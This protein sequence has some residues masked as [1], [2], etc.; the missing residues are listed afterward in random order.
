MPAGRPLKFQSAEKLQKMIEAYFAGEEEQLWTIT[1]LALA[2]DCDRD[3]LLN[4]EKREHTD[5]E[6][7]RLIKRAKDKVQ[8]A[9]ER[10]LRRKGRSGDIF[11]L[12]NFGWTDQRQI[13]H[14]TKGNPIG[15]LDGI[16]SDN[17]DE[18]G[19]ADEGQDSSAA[20]R[21]LSVEDHQRP[22]VLDAPGTEGQ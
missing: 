4:Y 20:G 10:D 2:L 12:K 1:G 11:A 5:P 8:N 16:R 18:E 3:T 13:D 7:F 19:D 6:I 14:T 21:D 17:S 22:S 9:Y 15:I